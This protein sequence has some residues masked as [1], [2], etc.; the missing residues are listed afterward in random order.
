MFLKKEPYWFT[1][2]F[3]TN[4]SWRSCRTVALKEIRI[5]D[6]YCATL[7]N[8]NIVKEKYLVSQRFKTPQKPQMKNKNKYKKPPK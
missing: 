2:N 8:T 4:Y 7:L 6:R 5:D 1:Y 3:K